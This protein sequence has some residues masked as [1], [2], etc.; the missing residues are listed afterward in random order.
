MP[1]TNFGF[2]FTFTVAG[3]APLKP[4][5][6]PDAEVRV[7]TPDYF[8]TMGIRMVRGRG[9]TPLDVAGGNRV[10]LITET[11]A[12][13]FFPNEEPIGKHVTFGV[14]ARRFVAPRG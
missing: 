14:H 11:A 12:R 5:D 4:S 7:A 6:E 1:L 3:R 2:G 13:K 8:P 9:F 10:L